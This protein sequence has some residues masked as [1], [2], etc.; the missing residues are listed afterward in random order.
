MVY[1][2][3]C[4]LLQRSFLVAPKIFPVA[5]AIMKPFLSEDTRRKI[6]VLGGNCAWS[7]H[8]IDVFSDGRMCKTTLHVM[9]SVF[10]CR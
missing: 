5:Y 3:V 9:Q 8:S 2:L 6:Q 1:L 4:K 10:V 7:T